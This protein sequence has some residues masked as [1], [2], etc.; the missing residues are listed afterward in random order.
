MPAALQVSQ[1]DDGHLV[2][3]SGH[4]QSLDEFDDERRDSAGRRGE[5][6]RLQRVERELRESERRDDG[7]ARRVSRLQGE[8]DELRERRGGGGRTEQLEELHRESLRRQGEGR[9]RTVREE[10]ERRVRERFHARRGREEGRREDG[11]RT[12]V[13]DKKFD[14]D[15]TYEKEYAWDPGHVSVG[16]IK[17][18]HALKDFDRTKS[19][20]REGAMQDDQ[21]MHLPELIPQHL[22]GQGL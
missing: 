15:S 6:P 2:V 21:H 10:A 11:R 18:Q 16:E 22:P 4:E 3:D 8:V 17:F 5:S 1:D 7:L 19:I 13:K 20:L 14:P 9:R 12:A